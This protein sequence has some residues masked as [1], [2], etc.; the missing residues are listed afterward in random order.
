MV[1]LDEVPY[2]YRGCILL[3]QAIERQAIVDYLKG[4]YD[5]YLY[6]NGMSKYKGKLKPLTD[7]TSIK[8]LLRCPKEIKV[9]YIKTRLKEY[10]QYGIDYCIKKWNMTYNGVY[11][12]IR[13]YAGIYSK[14]DVGL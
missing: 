3:I 12:F 7:N 10:Y 6:L 9:H 2:E 1:D 11:L 5:A 14:K 8:D 4:S 13:K